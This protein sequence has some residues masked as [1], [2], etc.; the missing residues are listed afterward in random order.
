MAASR[1]QD[2]L[3]SS[4][5]CAVTYITRGCFHD[6]EAYETNFFVATFDTVSCPE[7]LKLVKHIATSDTEIFLHH[8]R[9]FQRVPCFSCYSP[10]HLSA[11]CGGRKGTFQSQHHREFTGV[12]VAPPHVSGL[13]S[14]HLDV[15]GRL[16]NI[17]GLVDTLVAITANLKAD[18]DK[19]PPV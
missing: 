1:I 16:Q 6:S 17:S 19:P 12:P 9:Q 18:N 5:S 3:A 11:K 13:T 10:Y 7:Q 4:V 15:V 14:N 2:I 8:F